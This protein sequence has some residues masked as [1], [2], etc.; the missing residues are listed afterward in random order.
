MHHNMKQII[1]GDIHGRD[2][3]K[4]VIN[5]E[6]EFDRVIFLGDY[7]DSF[8]IEP[9]KQLENF[10]DIVQFKKDNMNKVILLIGNHD[11][12]YWPGTDEKYSGYQPV[13]RS[14]FE[15]SL[16]KNKDILQ[17]CF[18]DEHDTVYVHAGLTLTWLNNVGI[19]APS[20]QSVV[21]DVNELFVY[22]PFKF[23]FYDEDRSHCGDNINQGPFWVRERALYKDGI[24][25]L[26]VVGHTVVDQIDHV[27]KSIRRGFFMID[28][29][30][31]KMKQYLVCND[32]KFEI[33]RL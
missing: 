9:I 25:Q 5:Q 16:N 7:F 22:K 13:M 32:D 33:K 12:Q 28:R 29:L 17:I 23:S 11:Y 27:N 20:I 26:M 31:G 10:Y 3:W 4:E 2:H 15:E 21:R 24:S 1:L 18:V 19:G 8:D 14:Q 6:K 30:H